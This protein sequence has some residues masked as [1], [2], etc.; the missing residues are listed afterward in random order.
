MRNRAA[1][2]NW[3]ATAKVDIVASGIC[4]TCAATTVSIMEEYWDDFWERT[5]QTLIWVLPPNV[6]P[7]LYLAHWPVGPVRRRGSYWR[8]FH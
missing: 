1:P 4:A 2:R 6:L 7:L 5:V 8:D 3:Q